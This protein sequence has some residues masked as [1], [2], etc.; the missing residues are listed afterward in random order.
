[1]EEPSPTASAIISFAQKLENDSTIFYKELIEMHVQDRETFSTFAEE[2]KRNKVLVTRTYQETISDA[3]EACFS[4]RGLDLNDY[5]TELTLTRNMSYPNALK[6]AIE[7]ED[8]AVKFYLDVAERSDSLLATIP[9]AF[10]KVAERRGNRKLKLKS[11]L[12]KLKH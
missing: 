8:K 4:F 9:R 5:M 3:I 2:G 6:K 12:D 10:R 1:M 11:L 7:L